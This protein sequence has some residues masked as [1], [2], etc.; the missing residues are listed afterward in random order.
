MVE[1]RSQVFIKMRTYVPM[2]GGTYVL[3]GVVRMSRWRLKWPYLRTRLEI[4]DWERPT[5]LAI[6]VWLNWSMR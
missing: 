6:S 2:G 4:A 3:L 5:S 1:R